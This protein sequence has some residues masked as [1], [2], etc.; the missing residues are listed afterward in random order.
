MWIARLGRS[1]L[2]E[3][4]ATLPSLMKYFIFFFSYLVAAVDR[5]NC[6]QQNDDYYQY[7]GA[8]QDH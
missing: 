2:S 7:L 8:F 4:D 1:S 6:P 3:K 5:V